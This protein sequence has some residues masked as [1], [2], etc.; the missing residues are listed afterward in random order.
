MHEREPVIWPVW[1][2]I[3]VLCATYA[4]IHIPYNLLYE[5]APVSGKWSELIINGIF[6]TDLV[7]RIMRMRS[8]LNRSRTWS[9]SHNW[10]LVDV[11]AAIPFHL[12]PIASVFELFRLVKLGRVSQ[13]LRYWQRRHLRH[14]NLL[15]FA[16]FVYWLFVSVHWIAC[17][18]VGLRTF[19][20]NEFTPYLDALYWTLTTIATVGY[21]DI[22]PSSNAQKIYAMGVMIGGIGVTGFVVANLATLL[23]NIDPARRNY[24]R[25]MERLSSFMYYRNIPDPLQRRI[26]DYYEYV[27][28]KRIDYDESDILQTL[29]PSLA[30]EVSMFLK[31]D[32]IERV[33]LFSGA[34][35][36][37]IREIASQLQSIIFTPGD[38]IMRRGERGTDM[39][40]ISRGTVDILAQD[41]ESVIATLGDGDF[42]GEIALFL[43]LPRTATARAV[44]YCDLYRLD[45]EMF[46]RVIAHFPEV[47]EQ[48]REKADRRFRKQGD[49][50]EMS[51]DL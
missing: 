41:D 5:S 2:A 24:S 37:F 38:R 26:R 35:D 4:A 27:W 42:F 9:P 23:A 36:A 15:G 18:W 40:F 39:Y 11:I 34:S 10:L 45:K 28:E 8:M 33:P 20:G 29:P 19:D 12:L 46:N 1:D 48:I 30:I 50:S 14:Y 49:E 44:D 6:F 25:S 7:V 17:G 21:G 51:S 31:R 13:L 22:T 16:F 32:I 3:V 47:G 43:N